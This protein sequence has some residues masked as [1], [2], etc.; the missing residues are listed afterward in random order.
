MPRLPGGMGWDVLLPM[1]QGKLLVDPR[2]NGANRELII[3]AAE[4][5]KKKLR[6]LSKPQKQSTTRI[7]LRS[8]W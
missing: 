7:G 4:E 2:Y 5:A 1:A 8:G 3:R 6:T